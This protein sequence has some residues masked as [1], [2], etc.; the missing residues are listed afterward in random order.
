MLNRRSGVQ[1]SSGAFGAC[2]S[3]GRAVVRMDRDDPEL[4][5]HKHL[6]GAIDNGYFFSNKDR[7]VAG[8]IPAHPTHRVVAQS[9]E[10]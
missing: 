2:S 7:E 1:F 9:A 8:S 4:W 3:V 6:C 5:Y 10:R